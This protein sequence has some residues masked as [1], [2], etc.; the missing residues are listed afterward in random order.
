MRPPTRRRQPRRDRAV[1]S[2]GTILAELAAAA[3]YVPSAEHK[4]Q[5]GPAG[6]AHLRTDA[7]RCPRDLTAE[8]AQSWLAE[9]IAK[10]DVGGLWGDMPYPQ[11]VWKRVQDTVFEARVSNAEQGWYHG[12]PLDP[13]EWPRWL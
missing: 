6:I 12:Y 5:Y 2:D 7:T 9:A 1:P 3:R 10:G 11:L 8:Q 13:T 4:D